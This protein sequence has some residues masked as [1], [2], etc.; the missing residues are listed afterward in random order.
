MDV[1][2]KWNDDVAARFGV[3]KWQKGP[4]SGWDWKCHEG[5]G[6]TVSDFDKLPFDI[7][8]YIGEFLDKRQV[9][10]SQ[11]DEKMFFAGITEILRM[12]K[13]F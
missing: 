3:A 4:T 12:W 10:W 7:L 2:A 1:T 11:V 5:G 8:I 6:R 13:C 9:G